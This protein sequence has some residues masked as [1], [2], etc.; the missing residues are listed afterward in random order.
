MVVGGTAAA[1]VACCA[2]LPLALAAVGG[3][4]LGTLLGS[5]AVALAAVAVGIV[6]IVARRMR[7]SRAS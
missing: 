3:L 2:L 6:A 1:A 7:D 5:G 4:T